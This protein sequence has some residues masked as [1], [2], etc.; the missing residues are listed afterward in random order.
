MSSFSKL[1]Y[2]IY[3]LLTINRFLPDIAPLEGTAKGESPDWQNGSRDFGIE[4]VRAESKADGDAKAFSNEYLGRPIS[5]IPKNRLKKMSKRIYESDEHTLGAVDMF[6]YCGSLES[7][8]PDKDSPFAKPIVD[9]CEH[10][11]QLLNNNF[12][13]FRRNILC[14]YLLFSPDVDSARSI[15]KCYEKRAEKYKAAFSDLFFI[16]LSSVVYVDCRNRQIYYRDTIDD[17]FPEDMDRFVHIISPLPVFEDGMVLYDELK[18]HGIDLNYNSILDEKG[19][20]TDDFRRNP[21][22]TKESF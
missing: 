2:E 1:E 8:D 10:K 7:S 14:I 20:M 4:V 5:E 3:A 16:G 18:K 19:G 21:V 15:Y 6:S 12:R 17:S 13:Q 11:L 22:P 9:R